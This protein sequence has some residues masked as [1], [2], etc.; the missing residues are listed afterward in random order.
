MLC[1]QSDDSVTLSKELFVKIIHAYQNNLRV[2]FHCGQFDRRYCLDLY[3][4]EAQSASVSIE[5]AQ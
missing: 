4:S 5:H 2:E 1:R 3:A